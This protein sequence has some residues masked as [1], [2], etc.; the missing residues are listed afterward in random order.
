[1]I[2][3]RYGLALGISMGALLISITLDRLFAS[4]SPVL[5][6]IIQIPLLVL[7]VDEGRRYLIRSSGMSEEDINGAF[8]FA[9][10]MAAI[11][12]TSL[13]SDIRKTIS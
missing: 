3:H 8:F 6:F 1:M 12:A 9:A 4:M 7:I 13:F 10:P 5:Q 2:L 11:G